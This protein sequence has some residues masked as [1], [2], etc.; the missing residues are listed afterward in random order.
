MTS[1][2]NRRLRDALEACESIGQSTTGMDLA[3]FV[4]DRDVR[5]AV[6]YRLIVLAEALTHLARVDPETAGRVPALR[7]IVATRNRVVHAYHA[8]D[9]KIVWDIVRRR[10]PDLHATLVAL[11]EEPVG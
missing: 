10:L 7:Q 5:D 8:V 3:A 2:T 1:E 4:A 6:I 11:L 9:D